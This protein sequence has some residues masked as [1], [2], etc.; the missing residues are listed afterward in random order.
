M[1]TRAEGGEEAFSL[2]N[3]PLEALLISFISS[4]LSGMHYESSNCDAS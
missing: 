1:L 2:Y 3:L 4:S